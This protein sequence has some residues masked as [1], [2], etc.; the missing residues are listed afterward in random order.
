MGQIG[1]KMVKL[2]APARAH[3]SNGSSHSRCRY[4]AVLEWRYTLTRGD[5]DEN[6]L[7]GSLPFMQL[8]A[9]DANN[10]GRPA[11]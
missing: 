1:K 11:R 2:F 10:L 3:D 9:V 8:V 4:L 7:A 5:P 6:P